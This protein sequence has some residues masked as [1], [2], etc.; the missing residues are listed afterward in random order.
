MPSLR[1][2]QPRNW[3][4]RQRKSGRDAPIMSRS[5]VDRAN[6]EGLFDLRFGPRGY[7]AQ[8]VYRWTPMI[9]LKSRD[10]LNPRDISAVR[11]VGEHADPKTGR[12][13]ASVAIC[14][15][16]SWFKVPLES[17]EEAQELSEALFD[18]VTWLARPAPAK[19]ARVPSAEVRDLID[20]LRRG[21]PEAPDA[22]AEEGDEDHE[23]N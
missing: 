14:A 21:M 17:K 6:D 7:E 10:C 16:G 12:I 4:A 19:V 8:A 1:Q 15:N 3:R 23:A 20:D 22:P 18:L 9:M 5:A 11:I 13:G 2:R